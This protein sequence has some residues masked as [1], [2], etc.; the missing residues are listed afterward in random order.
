[1]REWERALKGKEKRKKTKT[2]F[3]QEKSPPPSLPSAKKEKKRVKLKSLRGGEKTKMDAW[4][5][6]VISPNSLKRKK[7]IGRS[8]PRKNEN[9]EGERQFHP[10]SEGDPSPLTLPRPEKR[11]EGKKTDR[12][13]QGE[14]RKGSG[15]GKRLRDLSPT[16]GSVR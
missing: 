2:S 10:P 4:S 16:T 11:R 15:G 1:V 9:R 3:L 5:R 8:R 12:T 7:R 13:V 14:K 6:S